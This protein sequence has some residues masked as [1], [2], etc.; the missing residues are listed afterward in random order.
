MS[1]DF[2]GPLA[3]SDLDG[4]RIAFRKGGDG[5]PLLLLHGFP[6]THAM[7]AHVAPILAD[8][9]TVIASD[10][11]GYGDSTLPGTLEAMSFRAMGADMLALM[12][13]LGFDRFHLAGHDRGARVAHRMTLDAPGRIASLALMD[14]V[15][16]LHLL[17]T[18]THPVARAYYHWFYLAQPAPFPETMIAAD[19]DHFFE[20]CL[21]GFG[22]AELSDFE[23][24][25]LA[26]YRRSWR[27][28]ACI[29]AMCNDYRAAIDIDIGDDRADLHRRV[30]CPTLV[31]YGADG[32]MARAMDVPATWADRL[33]EMRSV[34]IP[35]GHFF[36]DQFPAE[37]AQA[38]A[39][40]H[41]SVQISP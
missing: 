27:R 11:R 18:L 22:K 37:T 9:F 30:T 12:T 7:W 34:G 5:P 41:G 10:L 16:T 3:F 23:A 2:L 36:P 14:I 4:I 28:P 21:L 40:F 8:R 24:D 32:A 26:E 19:P 20:R 29:A 15:P 6:Q 17:E 25:Q 31:A 33:D 13:A 39:A 38:L 35:G 1:L